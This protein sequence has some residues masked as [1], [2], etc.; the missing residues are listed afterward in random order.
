MAARLHGRRL[1]GKLTVQSGA[2]AVVA[3][4]IDSL[5][6]HAAPEFIKTPLDP[7]ASVP[8]LPPAYMDRPDLS[9]PLIERLL[10][11]SSTVAV[12]AIEGMG[13]VCGQAF[14]PGVP[15]LHGGR[16]SQPPER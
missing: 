11:S 12:T 8:P 13:G 3:G 10:S 7:F 16:V 4:K 14:E 5:V 1:V 6:I 9:E 15:C 2:N